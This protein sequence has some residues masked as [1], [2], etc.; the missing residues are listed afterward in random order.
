MSA[1]KKKILIVDDDEP[2]ARLLARFMRE[3]D[4]AVA[5]NG[6]AGLERAIEFR[7][8]L[9]VTDV[10]MPEVDG[11]EMVRQMKKDPVLRRMPVIMLTAVTDAPNVASGIS[12]GARHFIPKPV[13]IDHLM[14]VV[15]KT[16]RDVAERAETSG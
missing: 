5:A 15:E 4:V 14:R 6:R 2:T 9:V 8:D 12:A 13:S 10:W 3:Y 1:A 11:I 7:P 16:L